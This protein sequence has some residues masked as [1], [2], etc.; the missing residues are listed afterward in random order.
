MEARKLKYR[1]NKD[2]ANDTIF[3]VHEY[4][5][6]IQSREVF[7][8][9]Y[10][11]TESETE[12]EPGMDYR[13]ASGLIKNVTLLNN[14]GTENILVHQFSCGG[15]WE[16]GMAMYDTIKASIADVTIL[17]YAHARSMS[18]ITLQAATTR[19]LMPDC[20]V[21][22]HHGTLGMVDRATPVVENIKFSDEH[23]KP[24]MLEIYADRCKS[25]KFFKEKK[26]NRAGVTAFIAQMLQEKTDWIM[27]A[28]EAVHYGFADGIFGKRGFESLQRI[29]G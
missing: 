3:T 12:E 11:H 1:L 8:H 2:A 6:N 18:S 15:E 9:S 5:V 22:I 10:V 19:V 24:R 21:L 27:T 16:Y 7:L 28:E 29:R 13:M 17:A 23:D 26:M 25:G 14:Q 4:G 20:T